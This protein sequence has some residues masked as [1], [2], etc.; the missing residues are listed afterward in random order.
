MV[1]ATGLVPEVRD[2]DVPGGIA[3][4]EHG[5]LVSNR[6]SGLLAVGCARAPSDV[7]RSVQDATAASARVMQ[8]GGG[9]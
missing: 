8:L 2:I 9:R 3:K 4:D 7:V 6:P 1:L 5:F